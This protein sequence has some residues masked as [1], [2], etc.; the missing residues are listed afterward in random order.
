MRA[1]IPL[2]EPGI[3]WGSPLTSSRT[4]VIADG[5]YDALV[6]VHTSCAATFLRVSELAPAIVPPRLT[7]AAEP[8][9]LTG[10]SCLVPRGKLV[11]VAPCSQPSGCWPSALTRRVAR[12]VLVAWSGT[13][14]GSGI[15]FVLVESK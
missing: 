10:D 13:N 4:E 15:R 3:C 12:S 5:P 9:I 2:G 11:W 1:A 6:S 14:T 8:S 7:T